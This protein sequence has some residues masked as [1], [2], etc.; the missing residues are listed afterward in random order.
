MDLKAMR[1]LAQKYSVDELN[2]YVNELETNG[3]CECSEKQ[4]PCEVMNDLLQAMEVRKSM[5]AGLSVQE[6]V[7]E[8]SKRVRSVLS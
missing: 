6:A 8:F 3:R 5:D 2:A 7:R 1:E 4:D